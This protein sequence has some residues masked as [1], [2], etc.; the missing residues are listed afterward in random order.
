MLLLP[1]V[2]AAMVAIADYGVAGFVWVC[3]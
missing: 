3:G 1:L 2:I